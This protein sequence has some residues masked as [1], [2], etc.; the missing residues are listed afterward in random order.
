[1]VNFFGIPVSGTVGF[2]ARRGFFPMRKYGPNDGVLLLADMIFPGGITL[3]ELGGDHFL[4]NDHP[5]I[6]AVALAST[7]I[8]WLEDEKALPHITREFK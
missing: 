2:R 7:V 8:R 4:M 3:T 5:D 1:V 6:T